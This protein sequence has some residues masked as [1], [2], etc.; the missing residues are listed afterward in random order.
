MLKFIHRF[1]KRINA[2]VFVLNTRAGSKMNKKF[3]A[4]LSGCALWYPT[5]VLRFK[6]YNS[7][8]VVP[9]D[10]PSNWFTLHP[11][12]NPEVVESMHV[13]YKQKSERIITEIC[14]GKY[15]GKAWGSLPLDLLLLPVS[16][17]FYFLGRFLLAKTYFADHT[18]T[19]CG[20]CARNCPV[21]AIEMRK[22]LPFWKINCESCMRCISNCP[23][24]SIQTNHLFQ[25]IVW[26]VLYY[27][28]YLVTKQT[29][30]ALNI[31][32]Y[33]F[34]GMMLLFAYSIIVTF[35][36]IP[37]FNLIFSLQHYKSFRKLLSLTSITRLK[38]WRRYKYDA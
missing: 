33:G 6:R 22:G 20:K 28:V 26:G 13:Y 36:A 8:G 2:D 17:L 21:E 11:A 29:D 35:L 5:L 3:M 32:P 25:L 4:G 34:A 30:I 16:L 7:R 15:Q 14:S 1:P 24:R 27:L 9:I 31:D 18:C 38:F 12:L 23:D 37:L 10:L 19:S